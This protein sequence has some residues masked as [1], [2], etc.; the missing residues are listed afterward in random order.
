M[1]ESNSALRRT[2][3]PLK[4]AGATHDADFGAPLSDEDLALSPGG[5]RN[6]I[7]RRTPLSMSVTL[8]MRTVSSLTPGAISVPD[9][10]NNGPRVPARK[11]AKPLPSRSA[12]MPSRRRSP[13]GAAGAF[14]GAGV[15]APKSRASA[16]RCTGSPGA[17]T[18][19]METG[20]GPNHFQPQCA[21]TI[22]S[23][24]SAAMSAAPAAS[25]QVSGNEGG[26]DVL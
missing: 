12:K 22:A 8:A 24:A 4:P 23:N 6:A 5:G 1:P 10:I 17:I 7:S 26:V 21:T 11:R 20:V 2:T 25:R 19:G 14:F 3:G 16:I 13:V 15:A 9:A 18:G